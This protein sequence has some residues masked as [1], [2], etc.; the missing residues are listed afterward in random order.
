MKFEGLQRLMLQQVVDL[1]ELSAS[2]S[3]DMATTGTLEF[4]DLDAGLLAIE[5][6]S[7]DRV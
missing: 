3:I 5:H 6:T 1:S 4:N 7:V 2:T